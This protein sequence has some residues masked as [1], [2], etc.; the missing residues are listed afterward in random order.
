MMEKMND[1]ADTDEQNQKGSLLLAGVGA[2]LGASLGAFA[3]FLI[4]FYVNYQIG[5]IAVASGALAGLGAVR[6]GKRNGVD[7]GCIAAIAGLAGILGGSYASYYAAVRSDETREEVVSAVTEMEGYDEASFEDRE[8]AIEAVYQ[9]FLDTVTYFDYAEDGLMFL[10]LFGGFGVYYGYRTGVGD[11]AAQKVAYASPTED[12]EQFSEF[13]FLERGNSD[14]EDSDDED[15]KDE[16]SKDEDSK[17]ED[18]AVKK[19]VKTDWEH[20]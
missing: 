4:E 19:P 16:D 14:D 1:S 6:L 12:D 8:T 13:D 20:R 10:L 5:Y 15:S 9:D 7:V 2:F 17:D 3:W 18:S 11:S